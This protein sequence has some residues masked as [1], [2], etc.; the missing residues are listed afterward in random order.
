MKTID[1][2]Y[3]FIQLLFCTNREL[4]R[5]D[6]RGIYDVMFE[7]Y[8]KIYTEGRLVNVDLQDINDKFMAKFKKKK[9]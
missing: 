8:D 5:K 1:A 7:R 6:Y 9:K 2:E 3:Y 4:L